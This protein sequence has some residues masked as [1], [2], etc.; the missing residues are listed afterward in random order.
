MEDEKF[1]KNK[2][3]H[4]TQF[5]T[6]DAP[7]NNITY[8]NIALTDSIDNQ[9][10]LGEFLNNLLSNLPAL[11]LYYFIIIVENHFIGQT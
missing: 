6:T 9:L 11:L 3:E 2:T 10:P 4:D 5:Y 1:I 7:L 8:P